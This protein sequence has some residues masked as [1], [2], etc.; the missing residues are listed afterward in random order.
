MKKRMI[1]I[2]LIF[3]ILSCNE[4]IDQRT[5][6]FP[7][8]VE[9]VNELPTKDNFWIFI[10]AG[11]SNMA[12][13]GFV[14]PIYTLL[15][16]RILTINKDNNWI[17]AKEPLHFYEPSLTG[18][19]CG[20]SFA[21]TLIDSFPENITI[22][23]LPCAVGGSSIEHWIGDS[24]FRGVQLF[25]N[26]KN[27]V[28]YVKQ[29]GLIKGILWHQ[30]E[31]NA[32]SGLIS[33]YQNN[34][35]ELFLKFRTYVKNDSLPILIGELGSFA[36][37]EEKQ[38]RWDSINLIINKYA[39]NE[40]FISVINTNDLKNKGDNLHFNSKSQRIMGERFAKKYLEKR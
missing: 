1:F 6:N 18:L 32:K 39:T 28:D 38:N 33:T 2:F 31:S 16:N 29:Y 19:D 11:Q 4:K 27:K 22:G 20:L 9:F 24:T 12:G 23:I 26:F 30:G 8:K 25:T 37:P 21:K 3:V 34:L 5:I 35:D 36:I 13:R 7:K 17:Y 40:K 14:E 10:I 15:S